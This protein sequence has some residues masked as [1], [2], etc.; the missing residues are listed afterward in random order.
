[1]D[2]YCEGKW[3]LVE[4]KGAGVIIKGALIRGEKGKGRF[5]TLIGHFSK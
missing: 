3:E 1:M 4:G 2:S 5:Y